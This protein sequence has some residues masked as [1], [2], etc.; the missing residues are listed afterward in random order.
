ML[1]NATLELVRL[2]VD[3]I[4]RVHANL[5]RTPLLV[6]LHVDLADTQDPL[7]AMLPEAIFDRQEASY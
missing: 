2:L 6:P 4:D 5:Q 3:E 7:E 1:H